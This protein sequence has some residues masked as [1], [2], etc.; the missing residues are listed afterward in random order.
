MSVYGP[1]LSPTG[2]GN[3]MM[4]SNMLLPSPSSNLF[5]RSMN[6]LVS[7]FKGSVGDYG[8]FESFVGTTDDDLLGLMNPMG[9]ANTR[10][11]GLGMGNSTNSLPP[12]SPTTESLFTLDQ[13]A[14]LLTP[15]GTLRN[16]LLYQQAEFGNNYQQQES[17]YGD[18]SLISEDATQFKNPA[19]DYIVGSFLDTIESMTPS[20]SFNL[21]GFSDIKPSENI[22]ADGKPIDFNDDMLMLNFDDVASNLAIKNEAGVGQVVENGYPGQ[23]QAGLQTDMMDGNIGMGPMV[24]VGQ[25]NSYAD[26]IPGGKMHE[27]PQQQFHPS[28]KLNAGGLSNA[29]PRVKPSPST[30]RSSPQRSAPGF[31]SHLSPSR[32]PPAA[33]S[34]SPSL[35][36][37]PQANAHSSPSREASLRNFTHPSPY[38]HLPTPNGSPH[39]VLPNGLSHH[40]MSSMVHQ[41][42]PMPNIR[43]ASPAPYP[44][45]QRSPSHHPGSPQSYP[46][47]SSHPSSHTNANLQQSS[48]QKHDSQ[49][50]MLANPPILRSHG[51]PPMMPMGMP[52]MPMGMPMQM[53]M[54]V[55]MVPSM[56]VSMVPG[57]QMA[58][59]NMVPNQMMGY[60]AYPGMPQ[61]FTCTVPGCGKVFNKYIA[62]TQHVATIH[63]GHPGTTN[64][65]KA[66]PFRCEMC[67]QTFSRSHDLKRHYYIHTQEKPYRCKRCGKG[68]S[69]R[70]ALRRH[71][72]SVAEGKKVHCATGG[73]DDDDE[74]EEEGWDGEHKNA[75][76]ASEVKAENHSTDTSNSAPVDVGA[77]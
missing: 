28:G 30:L 76:V 68:F 7:N 74:E 62:L 61:M 10:Q 24:Q 57:M 70:D 72:R 58:G 13:N 4:P 36:G 44:H 65:T 53:G 20:S 48:A 38:Q 22:A 2:T 56:A 32:Q 23:L 33:R 52:V 1:L 46:Q 55:P 5:E 34:Q 37:R 12:L 59:M 21:N 43:H 15:G 51:P 35:S 9:H 19:F 73:D 60:N 42:Q 75:S 63:G 50:P 27:P 14:S 49:Q 29:S 41:Q 40:Q 18:P 31:S 16:D 67:P 69:R 8:D 71:E 47:H 39:Y 26:S 25:H 77:L 6:A 54:A 45:H 17:S 66:K 11:G 3:N 64:P